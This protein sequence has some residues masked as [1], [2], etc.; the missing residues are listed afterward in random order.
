[1][2]LN[3]LYC[4]ALEGLE[5]K[6]VEAEISFTKALPAFQITGLAGNAIQ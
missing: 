1:M 4:A 5:A 3:I 2:G 6:E